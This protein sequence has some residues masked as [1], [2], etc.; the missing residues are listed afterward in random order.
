MKDSRLLS[1]LN[2]KKKLD[3]KIRKLIIND[4][5]NKIRFSEKKFVGDLGE[6]YFFKHANTAFSSCSQKIQSNAAFD[7]YGTLKE[8]YKRTLTIKKDNLRIEVK[9]RYAQNGNNHLFG[10]KKDK[11]DLLAFVKLDDSY[12]CEYIGIVKVSKLKPDK[13]N[14]IKHRDYFTNNKE[15]VVVH[16]I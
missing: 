13:Q 4:T 12:R 6:Y 5:N 7:F 9:T 16:M 8:K 11:F 1:L 15:T 14:R 3:L 10:I 2:E